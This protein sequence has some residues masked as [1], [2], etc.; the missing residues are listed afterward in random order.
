MLFSSSVSALLL[1]FAPSNAPILLRR[2]VL[3]ENEHMRITLHH[4]RNNLSHLQYTALE[5]CTLDVSAMNEMLCVS[6]EVLDRGRT[7]QTT[8]DL[9]R[10]SAPSVR[11]TTTLLTWAL[12]HKKRLESLNQRTAIVASS[13]GALLRTVRVI[14]KTLGPRTPLLV[15][16]SVREAK[17]F[18][19]ASD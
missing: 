15:T 13:D 17:A 9:Q 18:M 3:L 5:G 8:W 14:L 7:F 10:A 11:A 19:Q 6:R 1:H 2:E 16:S 4:W 12:R